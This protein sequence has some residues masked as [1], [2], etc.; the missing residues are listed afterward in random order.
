M[1]ENDDKRLYHIN[2][3]NHWLVNQIQRDQEH[4]DELIEKWTICLILFGLVKRAA[5]ERS[6]SDNYDVNERIFNDSRDYAPFIVP[7]ITRMYNEDI[8]RTALA[9]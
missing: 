4:K 8:L 9:A 2:I 5:Y 1:T 6:K 7:V 3:D